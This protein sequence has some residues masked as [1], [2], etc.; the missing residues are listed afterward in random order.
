MKH[1]NYKLT[2]FR[3]DQTKVEYIKRSFASAVDTVD[4]DTTDIELSLGLIK[5]V[6]NAVAGPLLN[7]SPIG[8]SEKFLIEYVGGDTDD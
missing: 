1:K 5:H 4:G 6:F 3:C 2:N 7:D 8:A